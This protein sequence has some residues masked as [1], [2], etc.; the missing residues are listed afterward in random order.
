MKRS[1]RAIGWCEDHGKLLYVDRKTARQ[2]AREHRSHKNE[3]LCA[4]NP[5]FWHV[6]ELPPEVISGE[7]S[8]SE[9]FGSAS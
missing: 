4:M 5:L 9:Y 1:A 2:V 3:F 6:G 8:R 7:I